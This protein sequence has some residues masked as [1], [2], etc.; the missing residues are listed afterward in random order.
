MAFA[1]CNHCGR[2]RYLNSNNLC[3]DCATYP[4]VYNP[5]P[6]TATCSYCGKI[7]PVNSDG[8]CSSCNEI[9]RKRG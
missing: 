4:G 8:I 2:L 5:A 9:I 1:T 6:K 7:K 3:N